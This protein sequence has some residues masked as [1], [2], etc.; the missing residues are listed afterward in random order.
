MASVDEH[1]MSGNDP[2]APWGQVRRRLLGAAQAW[3]LY[4]VFVFLLSRL[5]LLGVS[6]LG[7]AMVMTRPRFDQLERFGPV[8]VGFCRWDCRFFVQIAEHG[9]QTADEAA[10]FPLLPILARAVSALGVPLHL[11]LLFVTNLACLGAFLVIYRIFEQLAGRDAARWGLAAYA[12]YPTGFFLGAVYSESLM[13]FFTALAAWLSMHRRHV[14][15]ALAVM[16]AALSRHVAL[17]AGVLLLGAQVQD[18]PDLRRFL[19]HP[20]VLAL[21]LPLLGT[22]AYMFW[23]HLQFGDPWMWYSNRLEYGE[24]AT[25]SL[26][27]VVA[28]G[29]PDVRVSY[30]MLFACLPLL[31][32]LSLLR[33]KEW[34]PLGMFSAALMAVFLSVGMYALGRF[35]VACWPAFLPVG[36][37]LARYQVLQL[38]LIMGLSIF[39]GLFFF[40]FSHEFHIL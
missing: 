34:L 38:P 10:F 4:P 36:I 16:L 6:H 30:F 39:Q 3:Y 17:A 12:A 2:S 14:V 27:Q 23:L 19:F 7:I 35:S 1:E 8:L 11:A 32:T 31:G 40:L 22:G 25:L 13:V 9:Y 5:T 24:M 26:A 29:F 18:R 37:A 28:R 21:G 33:R 15:A 20:A